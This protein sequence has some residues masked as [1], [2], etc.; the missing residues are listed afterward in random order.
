M[1]EPAKY[2]DNV[3]LGQFVLTGIP[4]DVFVDGTYLRITEP[5]DIE[6]PMYG[7]GMDQDG[8]MH[9]FDYRMIDHILIN[10]N[11]VTL[12]KYNKAIGATATKEEP[13]AEEEESEEETTKEESTMKLKPMLADIRKVKTNEDVNTARAAV[14]KEKEKVAAA[15]E[16][17]A[18]AQGKYAKEKMKA[19]KMEENADVTS[20]SEPYMF[21][22]GDMVRNI[23]P[24][25]THFGSMGIIQKLLTLPN[26][27]GTLVK[28]TV[29]N[30]G[31]TYSAGDL[32]TKTMDQLTLAHDGEEINFDDYSDDLDD[33]DVIDYDFGDDDADDDADDA[34][35]GDD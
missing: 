22:V 30:A 17:L 35:N 21:K 24:S 16:K 32:L 4:V 10:G 9:P 25:C 28:Y 8:G 3:T 11:N 27:M 20:V 31:D 19:A 1:A 6:D 18:D 23:N 7:S 34:E 26:D 29:T 2:F 12:D 14:Q 5:D 13:A 33:Y 15:E